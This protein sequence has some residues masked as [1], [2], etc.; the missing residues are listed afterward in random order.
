M[1][2]GATRPEPRWE[3]FAHRADIGVR[4]FGRTPDEALEQAALALTGILCDPATVRPRERV[5]LHCEAPDLEMLLVDWLNALI[6]EMATR[7]LLFSRFRVQ[8]EDHRLAGEAWGE[9]VDRARHQPAVEVKGA[10]Y[11]E[12]EVG[13]TSDGGWSAGCVVDV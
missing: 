3:H 4:G 10:T 9:P 7:H 8:P 11:T 2:N 12:L 13:R 5:S 6:Y 1:S